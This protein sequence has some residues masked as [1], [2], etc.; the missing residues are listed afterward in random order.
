MNMDALMEEYA[1]LI[2]PIIQDRKTPIVMTGLCIGG[3]MALRF[4]VELDRQGIATPSV[5]IIDGF[6]CRSDYGPGW[7]GIVNM[8]AASDELNERRNI[9]MHALSESFEQQHYKGNV[10]LVI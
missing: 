1:R 3:D 4:A 6:A 2:Q 10:S 5:M 8:P 9:I 7:G